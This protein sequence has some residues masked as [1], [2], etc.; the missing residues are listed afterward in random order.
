MDPTM[1]EQGIPGGLDTLPEITSGFSSPLTP[2]SPSSGAPSPTP[3][4]APASGDPQLV[5]S[6]PVTPLGFA[7]SESGP[8]APDPGHAFAE[9]SPASA[10]IPA[11]GFTAPEVGLSTTETEQDTVNPTLGFGAPPL[12]ITSTTVDHQLESD[13]SSDS[14]DDDPATFTITSRINMSSGVTYCALTVTEGHSKPPSLGQGKLGW[15]VGVEFRDACEAYFLTKEITDDKK[16][17]HVLSSFKD[18]KHKQWIK[19]N[20]TDLLKKPWEEF[21]NDF[22]TRWTEKHWDMNLS[23][24][25]CTFSQESAHF[26]EWAQDYRAQASHLE[27][28]PYAMD[29]KQIRAATF[30]A[31]TDFDEWLDAVNNKYELY[32]A[33]LVAA[34]EFLKSQ[35]ALAPPAKKQKVNHAL[36]SSGSVPASRSSTPVLGDND[37]NRVRCP[38]LTLDERKLLEANAGCFKCRKFFVSHRRAN[39]VEW[40]DS[41]KYRTL[42]KADVDRARAEKAGAAAATGTV[43][44]ATIT[45]VDNWDKSVEVKTVAATMGSMVRMNSAAD[46][47]QSENS[48]VSPISCPTLPWSALAFG[49]DEFPVPVSTLLDCGSQLVLISESCRARLNLPLRR[50]ARPFR[51]ELALPPSPTGSE[52][53]VD[54]SGPVFH[55]FYLGPPPK[56]TYAEQHR[57][58][59]QLSLAMRELRAE[60]RR[61]PRPED[62]PV[63]APA[64]GYSF[65]NVVFTSPG[66]S[67]AA[68]ALHTVDID[69]NWVMV[70]RFEVEVDDLPAER[71]VSNDTAPWLGAA[72]SASVAALVSKIES[73]MTAVTEQADAAKGRYWAKFDMTN[74]FFQTRM[75]PEDIP[76]TATSTP[77]GLFEWTVMPMGF[78]NSPQIHQR[79]MRRALAKF[80]GKFCHVYLDDI[81]VWSSSLEEHKR[82]L[83]LIL[84]AVRA[85]KLFLNAKK[86]VFCCTELKFLGHVIGRDGIKPD[87][88]KIDRVQKWPVPSLAKDVRRFLGLVRY[89]DPFLPQLAQHAEVLNQLT[90]KECDKLFPDWSPHHQRA[91]DSIRDLVLG[92]GCLTTINHNHPGENHIY[93]TCDAS[94]IGT[95][96]V[97]SFGPTW[98]SAR[99]VAFYSKPLQGAEAHY[100]THEKEMLAIVWALRKWRSDLIGTPFFIYTDHRTL[101]YFDTQ[102]DLSS[103]QLH[104]N[105]FLS[106]YEG[107]IVYVKGKDNTVAEVLSRVTYVEDSVAADADATSILQNGEDTSRVCM[108]VDRSTQYHTAVCLALAP[109]PAP[110]LVDDPAT[111]SQLGIAIDEGFLES[112]RDGYKTDLFV[113]S[114]ASAAPGMRTVQQRE[115]LWFIDDCLVVPDVP[116]VKETIFCLCHDSLGHWG[117]RKSYDAIR[118][119]FYWPGMCTQLEVSYIPGCNDCQYNK[120]RTHCP[121]G[122][123]H[124]LPVPVQPCASIA[125]DFIGPLPLDNGF[126][127]ILT[128][129]DRLG[130]DVRF[131]PCHTTDT[132][133]DIAEL[134]FTHWYCEN[135]L[136]VDIVSDR[137]KLFILNFWTTL[138]KLTG[139]ALK[140]SSMFHPQSDGSSE[141]TNKSLI[142]ALRFHVGRQ[143]KGWAKSLPLVRFHFMNTT[144]SSTGLL[145]FLLCLGYSPRVIPPLLKTP[146]DGPA[147]DIA[148]TDW[149]E[150]RAKMVSDAKDALV[151]AKV[152]QAANANDKR[153]P[154]PS[155]PVGSQV[156]LSMKH[157]RHAFKNRSDGRTAK[158]FA[159]WDG[160]YVVKAAHSEASTYTLDIPES[161]SM[162]PTFHASLLKVYHPNDDTSFPHRSHLQPPPLTF[163]DGSQEYFIWD[164]IDEKRRGRGY[165]YLVHWKGYGPEHDSWLPGRELVGT[166]ALDNWI[167]SFDL[168]KPS[169]SS[170]AGR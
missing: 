110:A 73:G 62:R 59:K 99:P 142:Q 25:L 134:F 47:Y 19:L 24:K 92:A 54:S 16:V 146:S 120:D 4:L 131:I 84:D 42:T 144:N 61:V 52:P 113:A 72:K 158:F 70:N 137:D 115:G 107:R 122:P 21:I 18:F 128:I 79:R 101:E 124:P 10:S 53:V 94:E 91:F 17:L 161:S 64:C 133:V 1:V 69:D 152:V 140:L 116:K 150:V 55:H 5:D 160:P 2:L 88:T 58:A 95:G 103:R 38:A 112:L 30:V 81:I 41:T 34:A 139:T 48:Y 132:A 129:T 130:T 169:L 121:A 126:D 14:S 6:G 22:L 156:M 33:D 93:V 97:L 155:F 31:I 12:L 117:F 125:M 28:T 100:P 76:L 167:S 165:R 147:G 66:S 67:M 119:S 23:D 149:L 85:H 102:R 56:M 37:A 104:W 157:R 44:A 168:D 83:Q 135:G 90:G 51:L 154:E 138:H 43:A 98:E 63:L 60:L 143:Q 159:R 145:P 86:S 8:P 166:D 127:A 13:T 29:E 89:L 49:E 96:A 118:N 153:G 68:F 57:I 123:L 164:I 109:T 71:T 15:D 136:P 105:E 162:F 148:A 114:L 80:I 75:H 170:V 87:G 151:H 7:A 11:S 20:R 35:Q 46:G 3:P 39:C 65:D 111:V 74:S 26:Y 78:K 27:G 45:E 163:D 36:A 108:L 82:N 77:L 50:L 40:P 32:T 106:D 141:R 9:S